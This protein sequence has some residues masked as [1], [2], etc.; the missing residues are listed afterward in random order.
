[1]KKNEV[2]KKVIL[3]CI[4][5]LILLG[6]LGIKYFQDT[7]KLME[8]ME[9]ITQENI[10]NTINYHVYYKNSLIKSFYNKEDAIEYS[11][12]HRYTYVTEKDKDEW[13]FDNFKPF[14]LYRDNKFINDY[15]TFSEAVFFA[16]EKE[17]SEIYFLS[18]KNLIWSNIEP[19]KK[20]ILLEVPTILQ[21]PELPRGCEVTSLAML[22]NYKGIN[23]DK[24]ELAKKI[25]KDTTP[26]T[27]KDGKTYYG[28]PN[29][30]FVGDMYSLE[31][32]GYGVYS[33]PIVELMEEYMPNKTIDLTGCEFEDLFQF[34]S[35][36]KPVWVITNTTYKKLDEDKFEI[37]I[38]PTG[39]VEIT[40]KLHSV[41]I[42]GYDEQYV[43]FNDP[44]YSQKNIKALKED[45]KEAW[46]Q[47]GR[48]AVSYID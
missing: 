25:K 42:T 16:K 30:G 26:M 13:I 37:W 18:N 6:Y 21:Y 12:R 10:Q 8:E 20:E 39:P 46:N 48:Q 19:I 1:M 4:V 41:V 31:N 24:M 2:K 36:G 45:F 7:N 17:K 33:G 29:D 22:L 5:S 23:V 27:K 34:V 43:Y 32:P 14:I 47:M 44:Y 3:F 11:K 9:N 35:R 15:D 28:N 38:T 40:Y